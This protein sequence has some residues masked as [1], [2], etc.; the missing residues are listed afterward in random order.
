VIASGHYRGDALVGLAWVY[1]QTA[2]VDRAI[3]TPDKA[4]RAG[5]GDTARKMLG[6]FY[7][8]KGYYDQALVYYEAL[9]KA[10]PKDGGL[11]ELVNATRAKLGKSPGG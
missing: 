4:V 2:D 1:F 10:H 9:L 5:A 3:A 6:H 11:I 8:K 7:F